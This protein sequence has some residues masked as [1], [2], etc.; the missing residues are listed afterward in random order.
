LLK[1]TLKLLL[2][3]QKLKK[4]LETK[5]YTEKKDEIEAELLSIAVDLNYR[6]QGVAKKLYLE[7][8]KYFSN[9]GVTKFKIIVGE[10]LREAQ[11]FYI[12]MGAKKNKRN[13]IA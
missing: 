2:R 3:P 12:K 13:R 4:F 11:K 10:N 5:N 9:K 7:L 1:T 8:C 6:G